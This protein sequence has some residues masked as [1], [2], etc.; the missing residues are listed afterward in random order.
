ML[1]PRPEKKS[2]VK[3]LDYGTGINVVRVL[4]VMNQRCGVE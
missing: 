4:A 3:S 1:L 2:E